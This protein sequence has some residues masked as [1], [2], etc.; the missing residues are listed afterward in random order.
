MNK[1]GNI[2]ISVVKIRE[3]DI[4]VIAMYRPPNGDI[5]IF[6]NNFNTL[7]EDS[8]CN[9]MIIVGDFN[10]DLGEPSDPTQVRYKRDFSNLIRKN[11]LNI[12][13]QTPTRITNRSTSTIDNILFKGMIFTEFVARNFETG[14]SDHL[15]Q[16]I[17]IDYGKN[18]QAKSRQDFTY[19]RKFSEINISIF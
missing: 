4:T 12:T 14:I 7:L 5:N 18:K 16:E 13:I 3:P 15:A 17:V 10:I 8:P 6:L 9:N 19:K 1:E 11:K 2:E